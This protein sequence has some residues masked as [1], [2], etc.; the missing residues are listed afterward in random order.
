MVTFNDENINI[1]DIQ[2]E[3]CKFTFLDLINKFK[4]EIIMQKIVSK[5]PDNYSMVL[6]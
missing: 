2:N 5:D 6:S 4:Y 3:D 1:E